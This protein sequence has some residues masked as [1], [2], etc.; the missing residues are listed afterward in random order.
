M[1]AR[2]LQ[3][4]LQG[5]VLSLLRRRTH[6]TSPTR[7][8]RAHRSGSVARPIHTF[9]F[10][11]VSQERLGGKA[12]LDSDDLRDLRELQESVRDSEVL[13]VLQSASVRSCGGLR[14]AN[15]ASASSQLEV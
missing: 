14:G 12:F 3:G 15:T 4:E 10:T 2:W 13:V 5:L 11:P 7:S 9:L 1:E 6:D 8:R